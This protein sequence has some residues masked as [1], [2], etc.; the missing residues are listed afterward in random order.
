MF[1]IALFFLI[2]EVSC[3]VNPIKLLILPSRLT[4]ASKK[5]YNITSL[6]MIIRYE[7]IVDGHLYLGRD[8]PIRIPGYDRNQ[9][10][11]RYVEKE[12][13]ISMIDGLIYWD[14]IVHLFLFLP[15]FVAFVVLILAA[16]GKIPKAKK[17]S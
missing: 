4:I 1:S 3:I 8:D 15:C 7:Y 6:R 2:F 9:Y 5:K 12:P 10:T 16:F 11:I 17:L 14:L 13:W